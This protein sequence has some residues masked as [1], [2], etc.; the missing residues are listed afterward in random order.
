MCEVLSHCCATSKTTEVR[1]CMAECA[2]TIA[3]RGLKLLRFHS[4]MDIHANPVVKVNVATS[5]IRTPISEG[6]EEER[7]KEDDIFAALPT[8]QDNLRLIEEGCGLKPTLPDI[9]MTPPVWRQVRSMRRSIS[10]HTLGDVGDHYPTPK[11]G[12][13]MYSSQLSLMEDLGSKVKLPRTPADDVASGSGSLLNP[14]SGMLK[15]MSS[16]TTHRPSIGTVDLK[17]SQEVGGA[18]RGVGVVW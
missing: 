2:S 7:E 11:G 10:D 14:L 12:G 13:I 8:S 3:K 18:S 1:P 6:V 4:R 9:S 16:W 5:P 17:G 15:R